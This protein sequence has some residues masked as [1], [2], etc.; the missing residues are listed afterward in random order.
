MDNRCDQAA[1]KDALQVI[2]KEQ[3]RIEAILPEWIEAMRLPGKPFGRFKYHAAQ[4]QPWLLYASSQMLSLAIDSGFWDRL[5]SERKN[6]WLEVLLSSQDSETGLFICPVVKAGVKTS[7]SFNSVNYHRALTMKLWRRFVQIGVK[8]RC[9][10]PP[11]EKV[12]P[13]YDELPVKLEALPWDKVVYSSGSQAGHWA[14]TRL[15]ELEENGRPLANDPYVMRIIEFLEKH[16]NPRTGFWGSSPDLADGMNGLLKTLLMY[17]LL[18][19][20]LP[21]AERIIDSILK[22]QSSGGSLG[23]GC[24]PWNAMALI[25][26]LVK[27]TDYRRSD[28]KS[29]TLCFVPTIFTRRQP[30]G[31]YSDLTRGCLPDISGVV[32]CESPQPV[33]DLLGNAQ[34]LGMLKMANDLLA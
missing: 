6:E 1:V 15:H 34:T 14:A 31:L 12:A 2:R 5:D 32:L 11:A 30:D 28:I 26:F 19:R 33:S 24:A 21:R 7:P 25:S 29:A 22:I 16:Q 20:P 23:D 8:I 10:L 9:R 4:T 17:Q 13:A 27:Q 3:E 18:K